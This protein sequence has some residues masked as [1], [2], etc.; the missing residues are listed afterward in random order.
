[1]ER[2]RHLRREAVRTRQEVIAQ[3]VRRRERGLLHPAANLSCKHKHKHQHRQKRKRRYNKDGALENE[4]ERG[5]AMR[6][7]GVV[8]IERT[9]R[10]EQRA[11][12]DRE[13]AWKGRRKAGRRKRHDKKRKTGRA[14]Y[15]KKNG[16]RCRTSS[17]K[18]RSTR[19]GS[20]SSRRAR[21]IRRKRERRRKRVCRRGSIISTAN[22]TDGKTN[23]RIRRRS[24]TE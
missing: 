11:S 19:T 18:A 10:R 17:K 7:K 5:E 13:R 22:S 12:L 16:N 8:V 2:E 1:M 6:E 9:V 23:R 20:R 15:R 3:R 4:A 24:K 14:V 21:R